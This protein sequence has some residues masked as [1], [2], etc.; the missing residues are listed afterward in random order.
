MKL[1]NTY[2]NKLE[3]FRS[4]K[5]NQVSMYVCGPTVYNYIHIGN[6]R[7]VVVFDTLRRFFEAKGYTVLFASNFTD[8]DDRIIQKAIDEH[9]SEAEVSAFYIEQFIKDLE[10]LGCK[11]DYI[12]PRVTEYIAQIISYI[13]ELVSSGFAYVVNG[14]VFFRVG[15]IDEYGTLSNRKLDDLISGA[16]VE[17][18]P[19]KE[20]PLDFVLWKKTDVGLAWDSRF[21][22]G[23]PG[24]HTECVVMIDDIFKGEIDIHG[25]GSDLIFPHHENEIAQAYALHAHHVARYWLH[26]GRLNIEGEKMSKSLGNFILVK[27][28]PGDMM[29][30]RLFLLSTHYRAPLNYNTEAF[31]AIQNDWTKTFQA[32]QTLFRTLDLADAFGSDMEVYDPDIRTMM[33]DFDHHLEQD[34]NTPNAISV[35][36]A[37]V[38]T[39]NTQLRKDA[40]IV[41]LKQSF[42]ALGYMLSILGLSISLSLLSSEDK[43]LYRKWEQMRKAKDFEQAD[44][45]RQ[46]LQEKNIV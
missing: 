25:G 15:K 43:E 1:F 24:W 4:I 29:A 38:K 23:R 35:L 39:I 13:E 3:D 11:T 16:R 36:Q 26:N 44:R 41:L 37:L 34:L 42:K 27:D 14:D 8:V 5:E 19:D 7:P 12:K 10:R 6:A 40:D 17:V 45:L 28:F 2:T 22:R 21:S 32:Y 31:Q 46:L 30:F 33:D 20:N 9:K 18:N